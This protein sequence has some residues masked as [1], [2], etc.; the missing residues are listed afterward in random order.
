MVE[1]LTQFDIVLSIYNQEQLIER[2]LKGIVTHTT[3][4]FNLILIFDG[5]TDKTE[6]IARK[7]LDKTKPRLLKNVLIDYAPNV[8]ETKA[9]N[10]GFKKSREKFM[11]TLQDDM[12]VNEYGWERRL[13]YPLRKFNDVFAVTARTAQDIGPMTEKLESQNYFENHA[14]KKR[15]LRRNLFC[16]RD[17]INRGPVA[18]NMEHLRA[19]NFL[20]ENF[21]PSD[22]DDADLCMRAWLTKNLRCGVYWISYISK[23][24]W[25]KARS[26]DSTMYAGNHI[27]RNAARLKERYGE[28]ISSRKKHSEDICIEESEIDY[29]SKIDRVKNFI[30]KIMGRL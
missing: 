4:P 17:T 2:V 22:L 24:E 23:R 11:I 28:Y 6:E 10:I 19:L 15:G 13:T 30:K 9:N 29:V 21:S 5:C 16:V 12:V 26:K 8:F 14:E 7:Y 27:P 25:G 1:Q 3:T 18:F 20:D